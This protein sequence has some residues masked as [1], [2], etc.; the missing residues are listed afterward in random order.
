MTQNIDKIMRKTWSSWY[1]DGLVEIAT[2]AVVLIMLLF[3]QVVG[4][5]QKG[6]LTSI[7]MGIGQP[8]ILLLVLI[9]AGKVVK[10]LKLRIT[11]PRTGYVEY[12]RSTPKRNISAFIIAA[13]ISLGLVIVSPTILQVVG[14]NFLPVISAFFISLCLAVFGWR[15]NVGRFYILAVIVLS[16]GGVIA[17]LRIPEYLGYPLL[18][19]VL[20]L[21][22]MISGTVTL[23]YFL[24]H[25][26]LL[27]CEE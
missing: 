17:W 25:T 13:I 11:F 10:T 12:S 15:S 3:Y 14:D 23:K 5:L 8:M 9:I 6:D 2:G 21:G 22:L 16:T 24:N 1:I 27:K 7:V 20:G 4:T 18:L 19:T 26:Q